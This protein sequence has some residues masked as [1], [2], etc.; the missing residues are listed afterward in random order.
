MGARFPAC[1]NDTLVTASVTST[2]ETIVLLSPTFS[3]TYD[4]APVGI[5]AYLIFTPGTGQTSVTFR[6]RRGPLLTS[7]L[8]NVAT[9]IV[10]TPGNAQDWSL[11]YIDIP[12]VVA[13]QQYCVTMTQA[14]GA[15]NATISDACIALL[16]L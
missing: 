12:G 11:V 1:G 4:N 7:T 10:T 16:G 9:P 6:L 13:N 3:L 2:T 15:G 8:V 14:G 5:N